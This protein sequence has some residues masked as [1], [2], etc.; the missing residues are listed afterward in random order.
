MKADALKGKAVVSIEDGQRVG[1]VDEVLFG[2]QPPHVAAL[3]VADDKQRAVIPF[4][5]LHSIGTDAITVPSAAA[6]AWGRAAAAAQELPNLRDLGKL[7]VVDEAGTFLG[8]PREV[9]I[10]PQ[11]GRI[12]RLQVHRGGV[13]GLGGD[14]YLVIGADIRSIGDDVMVVHGAAPAGP[15][16]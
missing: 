6:A 10:D 7:K 13:L 12:A 16:A 3:R 14:T 15:A 8:T 2:T 5:R 11:D 4:D 9:E 1:R